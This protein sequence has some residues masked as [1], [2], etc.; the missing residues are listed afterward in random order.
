VGRPAPERADAAKRSTRSFGV[1]RDDS[2]HDVPAPSFV[3]SVAV[4][5]GRSRSLGPDAR[6]VAVPDDVDDPRHTKARGRVS[7]PVTID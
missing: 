5:P 7:L 1:D 3:H 4:A 2:L 6:P